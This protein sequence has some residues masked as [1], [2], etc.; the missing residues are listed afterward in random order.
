ML[1]VLSRADILVSEGFDIL[2]ALI[3]VGLWCR[4][5][6]R[7]G[8]NSVSLSHGRFTV[9]FQRAGMEIFLMA[10]SAERSVQCQGLMAEAR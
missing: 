5:L 9:D 7:L 2:S 8:S 4:S 6:L 3:L 10:S 1:C